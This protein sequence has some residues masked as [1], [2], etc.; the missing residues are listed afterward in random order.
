[1]EQLPEAITFQ[2]ISVKILADQSSLLSVLL[3]QFAFPPL[4]RGIPLCVSLCKS[5]EHVQKTSVPLHKSFGC[6]SFCSQSISSN[7]YIFGRA[8]NQVSFRSYFS[9]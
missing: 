5:F 7:L 4:V 8:H 6:G 2:A 3:F 1:M 9:R